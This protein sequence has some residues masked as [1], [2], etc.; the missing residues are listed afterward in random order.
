MAKAERQ[1]FLI[2]RDTSNGSMWLT[3]EAPRV[4]WG[5]RDQAMVYRSKGEAARVIAQLHLGA[6]TI[7]TV[8]S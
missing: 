1:R 3:S 5:E 8:S 4:T 2:R 6:V 7:E